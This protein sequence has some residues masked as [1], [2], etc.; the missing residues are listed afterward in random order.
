MTQHD[1]F[2]HKAYGLRR[3]G[4]IGQE[5]PKNPVAI[6]F[7]P[8]AYWLRN[9]VYEFSDGTIGEVEGPRK[10]DATF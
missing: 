7:D 3:D 6:T 8:L 9:P 10:K 2:T 1:R 4:T 5:V